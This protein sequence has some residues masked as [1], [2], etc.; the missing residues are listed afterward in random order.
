MKSNLKWLL[1]VP[2]VAIVVG[3]G[4]AVPKLVSGSTRS[5]SSNA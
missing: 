4:Y 5:E 2:A 1:L 3:L